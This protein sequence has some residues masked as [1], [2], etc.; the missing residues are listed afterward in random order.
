MIIKKN[1][2]NNA[3]IVLD[4]GRELVIM[5]K[6]VA[7]QK[8]KGDF[9]DE[10]KIQ[11]IFEMR[12]QKN[13]QRLIEMIQEIPYEY[14]QLSEK[15]IS[16]AEKELN[17]QF[18]ESIYLTL[19]DHIHFAVTNYHEN[20]QIRNTLLYDIKRMYKKEYLVA[21]EALKIIYEHTGVMLPE[22]EAASITLHFI[23]ASGDHEI[24]EMV[25]IM[26]FVQEVL[27]ITK[28]TLA[29]D[30]DEDSINYYRFVNHLKFFAERVIS[31]SLYE[32]DD[33][34]LFEMV[35]TKYPDAYVCSQ[36][37]RDFVLNKYHLPLTYEE[38]LY[39][40]VHIERLRSSK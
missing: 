12:D 4:D 26:K 18:S 34:E 7:F 15:I 22:S 39:L 35:T 6:G 19:T 16:F 32:D 28:Y 14:M 33:Y 36:R 8:E 9:V 5:G 37:I 13:N 30:Y 20:I 10:T 21:T 27:N 23:N 38:L 17:I 3:A 2:N 11:K 29:M 25:E 1:L 24:P 40:T 31:N